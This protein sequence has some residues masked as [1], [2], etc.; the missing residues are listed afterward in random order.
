MDTG[1]SEESRPGLGFG[2]PPI[3]SLKLGMMV[4]VIHLLVSC[5]SSRFVLCAAYHHICGTWLQSWTCFIKRYMQ[6][7]SFSMSSSNLVCVP[8]VSVSTS[9]QNK[10]NTAA[11][12]CPAMRFILVGYRSHTS[13]IET[14]TSYWAGGRSELFQLQ[15]LGRNVVFDDLIAP[16]N[17]WYFEQS[18]GCLVGW[19]WFYLSRKSRSLHPAVMG[20][21]FTQCCMLW[22][23]SI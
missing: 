12:W 11:L 7:W 4:R 18:Q 19:M 22:M 15:F 3:Y 10:I 13:I 16:P 2:P 8:F 17:Q 21:Q 9:Y 20:S 5:S 6:I 14:A 1:S 23:Y